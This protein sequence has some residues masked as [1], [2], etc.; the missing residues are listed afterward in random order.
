[1]LSESFDGRSHNDRYI[2]TC[3]V[4]AKDFLDE[5]EKGSLYCKIS[6][7]KEECNI[8]LDIFNS[9]LDYANVRRI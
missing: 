1:M 3:F 7:L 6:Y 4:Y 9:V 5:K 8:D 2:K